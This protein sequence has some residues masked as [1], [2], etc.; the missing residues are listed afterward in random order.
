MNAVGHIGAREDQ[1][2]DHEDAGEIPYLST[3]LTY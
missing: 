2:P 1:G 3:Y